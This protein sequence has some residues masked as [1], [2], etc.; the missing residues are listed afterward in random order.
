MVPSSSVKSNFPAAALPISYGSPPSF[1][2][3]LS[4]REIYGTNYGAA[5]C[6]NIGRVWLLLILITG[7]D[8]RVRMLW[9]KNQILASSALEDSIPRYPGM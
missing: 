1:D 5:V 2:I 3:L 9:Q 8:V 4:I 7:M 6:M